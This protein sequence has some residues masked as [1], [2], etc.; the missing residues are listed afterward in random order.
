MPKF[1][2]GD[3]VKLIEG[4]D[5][6]GWANWFIAPF[7][8]PISI[9]IDR[10]DNNYYW[11]KRS[12]GKVWEGSNN[13]F[14]ASSSI[15]AFEGICEQIPI[16]IENYSSKFRPNIILKS[17][18]T[19]LLIDNDYPLELIKESRES[20]F[21]I[22]SINL[23]GKCEIRRQDLQKCKNNAYGYHTD[24]NKLEKC[25]KR[26]KVKPSSSK[27]RLELIDNK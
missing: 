2:A 21:I 27:T 11:C 10:V 26:I 25:F 5:V 7:K 6:G 16:K 3:K 19:D 17:K 24:I 18:S 4:K 8:E 12:D 1:V 13:G 23:E 14:Q 20:N 9:I 22:F 15:S